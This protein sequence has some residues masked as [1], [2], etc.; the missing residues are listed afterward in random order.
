MAST[1]RGEIMTSDKTSSRRAVLQTIV[2]SALV[3]AA[4][5]SVL[6]AAAKSRLPSIIDLADG[7]RLRIKKIGNKHYLATREEGAKVVDEKPTGSFTAKNGEVVLLE[8]GKVM[9]ITPAAG[10]RG[11]SDSFLAFWQ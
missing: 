10:A 1:S 3:S 9:S 6:D 7:S 2:A 11:A 5:F 4:P 8:Q